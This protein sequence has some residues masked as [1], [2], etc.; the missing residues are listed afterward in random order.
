MV[1]AMEVQSSQSVPRLTV[2]M[3]IEAAAQSGNAGAKTAWRKMKSLWARRHRTTKVAGEEEDPNE[4]TEKP[5][6]PRWW[7][8][9][10]VAAIAPT[11][12]ERDLNAAKAGPDTAASR[13]GPG[14]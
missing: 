4:W 10:E 2:W 8:P 5:A 11:R 1:K 3:D 13:W 7:M 6:G 14:G 9:D 12:M